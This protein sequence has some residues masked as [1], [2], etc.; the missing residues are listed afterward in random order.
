MNVEVKR[1]GDDVMKREKLHVMMLS[2]AVADTVIEMINL[3]QL[4][5]Y[6]IMLVF[7]KS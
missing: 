3:V 2:A 4:G 6:E 7:V 5:C 1:L